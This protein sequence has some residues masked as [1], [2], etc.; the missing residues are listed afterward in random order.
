MRPAEPDFPKDYIGFRGKVA[1][2]VEQQLHRLPKLLL[3]QE[4]RVYPGFYVS[5]VDMIAMRMLRLSPGNETLSNILDHNRES[6]DGNPQPSA[7]PGPGFRHSS[8]NR[9]SLNR[10]SATPMSLLPFDARDA[11][12]GYDGAL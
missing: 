11:P 1:I 12:I 8:L 6:A 9:A 3:A 7:K 10:E 5:H 4:K 2:G